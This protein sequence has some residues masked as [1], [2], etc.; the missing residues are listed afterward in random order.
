MKEKDIDKTRKVLHSQKR[1]KIN[2]ISCY[3]TS[4]FQTL[5]LS[6]NTDAKEHRKPSST[7]TKKESKND[8]NS[9]DLS[10]TKACSEPKRI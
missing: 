6:A 9:T 10:Y 7:L 8:Q 4:I 5:Y 1:L 2:S 3:Q